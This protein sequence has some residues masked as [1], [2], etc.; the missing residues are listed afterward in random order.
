LLGWT[1]LEMVMVFAKNDL[2]RLI[3]FTTSTY[4]LLKI[5]EFFVADPDHPRPL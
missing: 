4:F 5:L 1:R 2:S 3:S